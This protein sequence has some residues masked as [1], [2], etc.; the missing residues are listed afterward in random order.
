[1]LFSNELN[2]PPNMQD[3]KQLVKANRVAQ[4]DIAKPIRQ[5]TITY[6][7]EHAIT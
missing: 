7:M 1:M 4:F 6:G 2:I 5:D 3:E